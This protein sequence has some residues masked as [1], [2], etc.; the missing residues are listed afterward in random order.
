M[1]LS[2][3]LVLSRLISD[4]NS[5]SGFRIVIAMS[6]MFIPA[7]LDLQFGFFQ[8]SS[9]AV[10]LSLCLGVLA[11]AIVEVDE[12]TKDRQKF[13]AT[14]IACFFIAA[15]SVELLLPYPVI[16]ALG[17]GISSFFFMMLASLG[18][19]Y[20]R[21]GF[22]AILIAIYTLIGHQEAAAWFESPILLALGALW[23]GIFAICWSYFSP[24]RTLREQLAQL[25]YAI[26][27]YQRQKSE[28][29]DTQKGNSREA[30]IETRQKLAI[31]N[32]SIMARIETSKNM[33]KGQYKANIRQKE[34]TILNQY[35][36]V[37]EQIHERISASQYLY[38]QLE[39]TFGR[40]QILEGFH[41]LL[42][43]LSD[44]CHQVGAHINDKNI[45]MRS[46]RLKWTI[47]ALSDQLFLLKQKLQAFDDNQEAMQALQ[48]IYD[49]LHGINELLISLNKVKTESTALVVD[50]ETQIKQPFWKVL[51]KAY[52]QKT[53]VFKHAVRISISLVIAFA[54]PTILELEN[55]FWILP[56]VLF[57]CQPSF[58]ETRK[59]LM[60]RSFGTLLG[61]VLSF[62]IFFLLPNATPQ[63]IL[64]VLSAFLFITYVRTNYGLA[65]IFIT[66]FVMI[67][68]NLLSPS[69]IEVLYAR[70]YETLVGCFLSFI[71]ISFIYPDWQFK[72]FPSLVNNH[73]LNSSRY[74]KQISQQYQFGKS[75]N[76]IFRKTRFNTFK[77]DASLTNAW[78]SMLIEPNSKQHLKREVYALVNR[79]DAL[80]CYIAALS[81][82]RHRIDSRSDLAILKQ[83]FKMTSEQIL[84]TYRPELKVIDK[85]SIDINAFQEYK[86]NLSD[87][88]KL[89]IE[90]LRLISFTAMDIQSLLK[91]IQSKAND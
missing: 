87:E 69:G 77:S 82:H 78:Q 12:N 54:I 1:Q 4:S 8:Q 66:I 68:T 13:I 39:N 28:L 24:N 53:P 6:C 18:M 17:L 60:L 74:F 89:I 35:F 64:M 51:Y 23:Y 26:G 21:I 14:V 38:S 81:S 47:Q 85:R 75:E 37:A 2:F 55:G 70:I 73:L 83:L 65:V 44:E 72:R 57:V 41:Q 16:F 20:S 5:H 11:S 52:E 48:A 30:I 32:I 29:F 91:I 7:L 42:L 50:S 88:A 58:S 86:D 80:T 56:T 79:C 22:G 63:A 84:Y 67:L 61:I 25:Y 40:S 59:R 49:N 27:R 36:L 10:S 33:I 3:P 90:Q 9:L 62:P 43:Q 71:A 15:S 76:L 46:K 34:L 45:Y 19:H 31:L